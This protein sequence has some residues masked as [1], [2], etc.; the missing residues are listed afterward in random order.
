MERSNL[1]L[2]A[3]CMFL[4]MMSVCMYTQGM[5]QPGIRVHM[6]GGTRLDVPFAAIERVTHGQDPLTEL[7]TLPAI[8]ISM[9]EPRHFRVEV[10]SAAA[11]GSLVF[12]R[13]VCWAR[14]RDPEARDSVLQ[15]AADGSLVDTLFIREE[16]TEFRFR[17]FAIGNGTVHYGP[18]A[19]L[20]I[21]VYPPGSGVVDVDGNVYATAQIGAHEWMLENLR[22]VRYA[23]GE[24]IT[25]MD[26]WTDWQYAD[27]GAWSYPQLDAQ[28]QAAVYGP[29]YNGYTVIDARNV[30][31]AD[32]HVA[33]EDDWRSLEQFVGVPEAELDNI[34]VRGAPQGAGGALKA[35]PYWSPPNVGATNASGFGARPGG[36]RASFDGGF[37]D[38]GYSGFFW[39]D[40]GTGLPAVRSLAHDNAG[41]SRSQINVRSGA[42]I[43]CVKD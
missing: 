14:N 7:P 13:G 29:L 39:V 2:C 38:D 4:A 5:A 8:S 1:L 23:N 43:R 22:A 35:V 34:G 21:P 20:A 28:G 15:T 12:A 33:N 36:L 31:P 40:T 9:T 30:C 16:D 19:V 41:V 37:Y 26:A 27:E 10:A 3:R 32:W 42:S 25:R 6:Q 18:V 24:S 17:S 11:N